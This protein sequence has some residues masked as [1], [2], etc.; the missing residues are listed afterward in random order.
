VAGRFDEVRFQR[1]AFQVAQFGLHA[2][3]ITLKKNTRT[4]WTRLIDKT[5]L[6]RK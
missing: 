5:S 1:R 3:A 6:V 4:K 2:T